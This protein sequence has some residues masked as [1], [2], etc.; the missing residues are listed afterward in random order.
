MNFRPPPIG[1]CMRNFKCFTKT[2]AALC[3]V[4][5]VST[6]FGADN[7]R[8]PGVSARQRAQRKRINQGVRSGEVTRDEAKSLRGEQKAVREEERAYKADGKL[9]PPERKDLHQDLNNSKDIYQQKHNGETRPGAALHPSAR[10]PAANAR[11]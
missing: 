9:T 4:A 2:L 10:T 6:T 1:N 5:I 3:A 8:D 11:E 7:P